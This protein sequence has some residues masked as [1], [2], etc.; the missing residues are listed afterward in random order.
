MRRVNTLAKAGIENMMVCKMACRPSAFPA[1][2]RILVTLKTLITLAIYGPTLKNP[3]ELP[4][5]ISKMKSM[6]EADTTKKSNLFQ[7]LS[8]YVLP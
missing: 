6:T 3:S 8:K 5:I 1:S 7:E 2:L 4:S